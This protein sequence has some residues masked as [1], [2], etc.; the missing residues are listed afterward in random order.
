MTNKTRKVTVAEIQ[1]SINTIAVG[2]IEE[3]EPKFN[4][5]HL[6]TPKGKIIIKT[7]LTDKEWLAS[8]NLTL[9][10][11]KRCSRKK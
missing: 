4:L 3:K 2:K 6:I 11:K 9:K 7:H 10:K 1:A 8:Q 5:I